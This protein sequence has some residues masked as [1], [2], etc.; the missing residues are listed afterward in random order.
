MTINGEPLKN[1]HPNRL[2]RTLEGLAEMNRTVNNRF[3]SDPINQD[4]RLNLPLEKCFLIFIQRQHKIKQEE[5]ENEDVEND[6][7]QDHTNEDEELDDLE[8]DYAKGSTDFF[9]G[10]NFRIINTS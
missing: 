8:D 10:L 7:T 1:P 4:L 5:L 6:K 3:Y 2:K 9:P